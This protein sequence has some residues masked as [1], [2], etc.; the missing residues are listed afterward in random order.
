[1]VAMPCLD[2]DFVIV[3]KLTGNHDVSHSPHPE[4]FETLLLH[5]DLFLEGESA[6]ADGR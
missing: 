1:M 6:F 2:F 4:I 5:V 3:V